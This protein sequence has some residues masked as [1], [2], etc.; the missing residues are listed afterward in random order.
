RKDEQQ[1]VLTQTDRERERE[2]AR[3]QAEERV[4]AQFRVFRGL[5]NLARVEEKT[6]QDVIQGM[7]AIAAEARLKGEPVPTTARAIYDQ[8]LAS[9]HLQKNAELR[10]LRAE[11]FIA[12]LLE[13]EKSHVPFPD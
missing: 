6:K 12:V 7:R 9:Y 5:M 2:V 11:R 3:R 10:E 8:T 13:V 1:R 4:E